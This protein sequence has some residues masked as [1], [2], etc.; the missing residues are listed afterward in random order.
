MASNNPP[1]AV[2]LGIKT[3]RGYFPITEPVPLVEAWREK[4]RLNCG[5]KHQRVWLLDPTSKPRRPIRTIGRWFNHDE[6]GARQAATRPPA[7][8]LL[9]KVPELDPGRPPSKRETSYSKIK[10][11]LALSRF[12]H[13]ETPAPAI[14]APAAPAE[15]R[16]RSFF[17][18]LM[19]PFAR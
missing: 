14:A 16:N 15:P 1:K 10:Q 13:M 18:R 5:H 19:N 8:E 3:S 4:R 7:A 2:E 17:R 6:D 12:L 11:L 9:R